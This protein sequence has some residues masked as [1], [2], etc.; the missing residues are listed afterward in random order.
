LNLRAPLA[1]HLTHLVLGGEGDYGDPEMI[2]VS[3]LTA[4]TSLEMLYNGERHRNGH[5][6]FSEEGLGALSSLT[7]LV[8]LE[9][10]LQH[11]LVTTT[12]V[13]E[14]FPPS[15]PFRTASFGS[16]FFQRYRGQ[17]H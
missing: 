15:L 6:F 14:P 13:G 10:D 11:V 5:P 16:D 2:A 7:G 4:L 8:H 17:T 12:K 9:L 1:A 3:S